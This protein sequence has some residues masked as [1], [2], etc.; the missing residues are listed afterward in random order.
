[1]FYYHPE[2]QCDVL[3]IAYDFLA[4]RARLDMPSDNCCSMA[5]CIALNSV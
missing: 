4:H 3:S 1:M 2:L 5:G